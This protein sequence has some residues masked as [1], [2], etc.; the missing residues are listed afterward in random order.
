MS[1][2]DVFLWEKNMCFVDMGDRFLRETVMWT[3][4]MPPFGRRSPLAEDDLILSY[5]IVSYNYAL[6]KMQP[7]KQLNTERLK[8]EL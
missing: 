1:M 2:G 6:I 5:P 7:K 3:W 4:K 8:T